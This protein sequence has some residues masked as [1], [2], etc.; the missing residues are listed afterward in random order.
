MGHRRLFSDAW[1]LKRGGTKQ[2]KMNFS[3]HFHSNILAIPC[4]LGQKA[5]CHLY[6]HK[7]PVY[8]V[9]T[10]SISFFKIRLKVYLPAQSIIWVWYIFVLLAFPSYQSV[11]HSELTT[12]VHGWFCAAYNVLL[13]CLSLSYLPKT[14]RQWWSLSC[15]RRLLYHLGGLLSNF[16]SSFNVSPSKNRKRQ[17]VSTSWQMCLGHNKYSSQCEHG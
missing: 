15:N 7:I 12:T 6:I 1:F 5:I 11:A 4:I 13:D 2:N 17:G 16:L 8:A 10:C 9:L 3:F 14:A